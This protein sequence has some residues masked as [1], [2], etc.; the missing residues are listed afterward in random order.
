MNELFRTAPVGENPVLDYVGVSHLL[1]TRQGASTRILS[2]W[3]KSLETTGL[4]YDQLLAESL[5]KA[6]MGA[7][8]ITTVNTRDLHSRAQQHQEGRRDKLVTNVVV[9]EWRCDPLPVGRSDFDQDKLNDIA[10]R[11]LPELMSAAVAGTNE[12]YRS[13][14]RP[15]ADIHLPRVDEISLGQFF[16]M[17]MLATVVEGRL[18]G[19]NPYGQPGVEGYK[20][21]MNRI[22]GR[23]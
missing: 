5:G 6:E 17:M 14:G 8:P 19:I 11:T 2:V 3:A 22:L 10:D 4:W 15:T 18:M 7:T 20:K 21:N 12:A 1:E 16:Q 9:D 23:G 13:D